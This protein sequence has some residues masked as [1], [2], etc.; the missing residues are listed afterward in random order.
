MSGELKVVA[1]L[2]KP[3]HTGHQ[4]LLGYEL[5]R[6][7]RLVL[8]SEATERIAALQAERDEALAKVAEMEK[9]AARYRW[10]RNE[11]GKAE[12]RTPFCVVGED[13]A[14][15]S[16][17]AGATLDAEVDAAIDALG[18]GRGEM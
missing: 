4:R 18:D 1:W 12:G 5:P 2:D 17:R 9:D 8:A 10:L 11:A 14:D 7:E 3:D 16:Y 15:C 6:A 13:D